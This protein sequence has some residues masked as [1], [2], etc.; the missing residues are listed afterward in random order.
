MYET[1]RQPCNHQVTQPTKMKIEIGHSTEATKLAQKPIK[2]SKIEK[3]D[4]LDC[5]KTHLA[6]LVDAC[7]EGWNLEIIGNRMECFKVVHRQTGSNTDILATNAL[8]KCQ[9]EDIQVRFC[10]SLRPIAS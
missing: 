2:L 6:T 7:E 4:G 9:E 8:S 1:K 5:T 3:C 10:S